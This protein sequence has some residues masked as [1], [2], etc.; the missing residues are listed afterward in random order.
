VCVAFGR[1]Q[2]GLSFVAEEEDVK[3]SGHTVKGPR[4]RSLP[5]CLFGDYHLPRTFTNVVLVCIES[6]EV[7]EKRIHAGK[8]GMG[9]QVDCLLTKI[10]LRINTIPQIKRHFLMESD[11]HGEDSD[12]IQIHK[13]DLDNN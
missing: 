9:H 5:W 1:I 12:V 4:R 6:M 8:Q 2:A 10:P 7:R 13:T 3:P 11:S